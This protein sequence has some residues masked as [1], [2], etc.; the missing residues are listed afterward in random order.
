M[1]KEL[2]AAFVSLGP[3]AQGNCHTKKADVGFS[4]GEL[5]GPLASQTTSTESCDSREG[6]SCCKAA[7]RYLFRLFLL[8]CQRYLPGFGRPFSHWGKA[9][10]PFP[11]GLPFVSLSSRPPR[12]QQ[13]PQEVENPL[14]GGDSC[15]FETT[16][17]NTLGAQ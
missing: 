5:K 17:K 14:A 10:P 1:K 3:K 8:P 2:K 15:N 11:R 7:L 9:Q 16:G 12:E 4:S 13:L 6:V